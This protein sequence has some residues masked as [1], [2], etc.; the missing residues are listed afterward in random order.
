ME[1]DYSLASQEKKES[2]TLRSEK[3]LLSLIGQIDADLM[4]GRRMT[5]AGLRCLRGCELRTFII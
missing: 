5:D 1:K 3:R 2:L 4:V